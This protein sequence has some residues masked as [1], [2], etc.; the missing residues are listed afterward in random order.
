MTDDSV[1][2]TVSGNNSKLFG[3]MIGNL[4]EVENTVSIPSKAMTA[5]YVTVPSS[6]VAI[7]GVVLI[8]LTP[9]TLIIVGLVIWIRRR[10]K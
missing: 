8:L 3:N 9:L 4:V 5:Q 7:I 1:D 2:K 10:K 6:S